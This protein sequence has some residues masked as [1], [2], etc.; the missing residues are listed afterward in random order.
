[1]D[2]LCLR[3]RWQR[4]NRRGVKMTIY[5]KTKCGCTIK[6]EDMKPTGPSTPYPLRCP[7]HNINNTTE[8]RFIFCA[9]CGEKR[10]IK[11]NNNCNS[12]LCVS[13]Q[14]ERTR[15]T[16]RAYSRNISKKGGRK[17]SKKNVGSQARTKFDKKKDLERRSSCK[18]AMSVCFR[19]YDQYNNMPCRGCKKFKRQEY[20]YEV[21]QTRGEVVVL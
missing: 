18:L 17:E 14:R 7:N 12:F 6:K 5:H 4:C 2:L 13:C 21:Y 10:V 8:F 9:K 1:M 15:A 20:N 16:M 11:G 3:H 19:K